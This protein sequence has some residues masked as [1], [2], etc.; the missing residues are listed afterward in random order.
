MPQV[1]LWT[2][3]GGLGL[4]AVS[5]FVEAASVKGD[6]SDDTAEALISGTIL[7]TM[8]I[9]LAMPP[10][11]R[12]LGRLFRWPTVLFLAA[13]LWC[14]PFGGWIGNTASGVGAILAL[15]LIILEFVAPWD[16][17]STPAWRREYRFPKVH[18]EERAR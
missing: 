13:L 3:V 10:S 9:A 6:Q 7:C 18:G 4:L 2:A 14:G 11:R 15:Q 8:A 1:M 5:A 16:R 12:W 17:R